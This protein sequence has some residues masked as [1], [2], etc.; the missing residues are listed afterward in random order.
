MHQIQRTDLPVKWVL[1]EYVFENIGTDVCDSFQIKE[2]TL[3][4]SK[5]IKSYGVVFVCMAT[6]TLYLEICS[7]LTANAYLAAFE[8]FT[9]RR[10]QPRFR[11]LHEFGWGRS[12]K[13]SMTTGRKQNPRALGTATDCLAS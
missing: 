7:D 2:G 9:I 1:S 11:Q 10:G 13:E 4:G 8:R 6:T 12:L 3:R 5:S